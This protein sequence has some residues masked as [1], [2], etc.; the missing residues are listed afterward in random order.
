M[1]HAEAFDIE[2]RDHNKAV[3]DKTYKEAVL[4]FLRK[5]L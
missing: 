2:G 5:R 4:E 1:P 3:G